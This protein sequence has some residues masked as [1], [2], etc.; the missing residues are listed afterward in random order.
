MR[1][2][3][4]TPA[5][6]AIAAIIATGGALEAASIETTLEFGPPAIEPGDI[7]C[8]V[9]ID[10]LPVFARPGLPLLPV[11]TLKV[12]LPQGERVA[13]VTAEPSG[14][15]DMD[16]PAPIEWEQPQTPMSWEGPFQRVPIL[17]AYQ[18][19]WQVS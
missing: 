3:V 8:L 16:L 14:T 4:L 10:D 9:R 7:T 19:I 17:Q 15:V 5:L 12:V 1:S 6:L 18:S 13:S 11:Y 2:R